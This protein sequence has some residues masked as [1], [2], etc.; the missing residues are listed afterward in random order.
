[1]RRGPTIGPIQAKEVSENVSPI[2][3]VPANPPPLDALFSFV[4]RPDGRRNSNAPRR[5][6]PNTQKTRAIKPFTQGLEPNWTTPNGPAIAVTKKPTPV[7]RTM[8][9]TQ[10]TNACAQPRCLGSPCTVLP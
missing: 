10:N 7:N 5:L 1:M 2:N 9:P 6:N 3:S 4:S 8:I